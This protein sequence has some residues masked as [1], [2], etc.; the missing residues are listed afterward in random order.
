MNQLV[1]YTHCPACGSADIKQVL[2][3][4]DYTVSGESFGIMECGNCSLRF[5]QDV[6]SAEC[7]GPYYK[8]ENYISHTDTT[9]GL[10]NRLYQTVRKRTLKQKRKL[11]E[12]QTAVSGGNLLD[13]GSGTGA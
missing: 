1:H 2:S 13:I 10:I 9:K 3:A 7:I 8:S 11:V 5:T 6:P 12:K 4:K